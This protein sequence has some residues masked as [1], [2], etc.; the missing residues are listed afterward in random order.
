LQIA[1]PTTLHAAPETNVAPCRDPA[2]AGFPFLGNAFLA[3]DHGV[4]PITGPMRHS[5]SPCGHEE[6]RQFGC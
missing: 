3:R 4:P 1:L 2:A 5:E 6:N